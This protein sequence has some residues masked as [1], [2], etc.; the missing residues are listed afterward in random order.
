MDLWSDD[1]DDDELYELAKKV[2]AHKR[3]SPPSLKD[4]CLDLTVKMHQTWND[5]F[6]EHEIRPFGK[7]RKPKC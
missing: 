5:L 1:D 6:H 4:L 7:I 3:P 2:Q